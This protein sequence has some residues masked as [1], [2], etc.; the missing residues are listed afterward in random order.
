MPPHK[1]VLY[2]FFF[3][4]ITLPYLATLYP[5]TTIFLNTLLPDVERQDID[6]RHRSGVETV[7]I[8]FWTE[9]LTTP[10]PY[11]DLP[12]PFE[13]DRLHGKIYQC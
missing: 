11:S 10:L 2:R 12:F 3:F 7:E 8:R 1:S 5:A 4:N 9:I 6:W 13:R